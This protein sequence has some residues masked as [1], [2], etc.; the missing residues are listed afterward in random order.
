[1]SWQFTERPRRALPPGTPPALT[2]PGGGAVGGGAGVV[3]P[4]RK[5]AFRINLMTGATGPAVGAEIPPMAFSGAAQT[6]PP[7]Q[8]L[9]NVAGKQL[10]SSDRRHILVSEQTDLT[11]WESYK[12]TV[13]DTAGNRV[14]EFRSH[15]A[16]VPFFV[17]DKLL[18][19]ETT[20]YRRRPAANEKAETDEDGLIDEPA[21]TRAISL[22]T[23]KEVWS[24]AVRE[25]VYRGP[26]PP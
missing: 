22:E 13:F 21:K 25:A 11:A 17:S 16:A 12:L 6:V 5:G 2:P 24:R 9:A 20:P 19:L 15:L 4:P 7:G 23:G 3:P 8:R 10:F 26:L 14:G 18:I 1:V